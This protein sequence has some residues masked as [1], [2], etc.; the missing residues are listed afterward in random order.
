MDIHIRQ[1]HKTGSTG[2]L[3][4]GDDLDRRLSWQQIEQFFYF[5]VLQ[6]HATQGPIAVD[7]E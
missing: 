3:R 5:I 1:I 6:C 4:S 2:D 7:A